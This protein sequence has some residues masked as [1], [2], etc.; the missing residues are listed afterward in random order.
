[1]S[2]PPHTLPAFLF[3]SN[4]SAPPHT[5]PAFPFPS[6]MSAPPHTLPAFLF[7]S[8]MSAP[9]HTL[10]AFPFLSNM[11][12]PPHTLPAFPFPSNMSAPLTPF[13]LFP[14]LQTCLLP[15]TP[16]QLFS[17]LQTCLLPLTPFQL[18]PFLQTCL[19]PLTPFQLFSFLQTCL[20]PLTP[21]Q[22]FSF[23]QTCLLPS[24]PSSFSLSFKHVSSPSLYLPQHYTHWTLVTQDRIQPGFNTPF[25]LFPFLQTCLFP[26]SISTTALHS[27]DTSDSR[28][29][30]AWIQ[31]TLP[32]F[33]F[34]PCLLP[35]PVKTLLVLLCDWKGSLE[36]ETSHLCAI[37]HSIHLA[38]LYAAA[39][40]YSH[41]KSGQVMV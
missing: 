35:L 32:A 19:L 29:D 22:L 36:T 2:A 38:N 39:D 20:L 24:H 23:L 21:F 13:Q 6:N 7:P 33:P 1:M 30:P 31:Y 40:C 18:F 11:S 9:P 37:K 14:F 27:L 17:F 28:Q 5:L 3:P 15:L 10:P 26:L 12:A 8:N 25:Q 34:Y 41:S 4:M 16:F